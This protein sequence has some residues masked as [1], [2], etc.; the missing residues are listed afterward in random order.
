MSACVCHQSGK[1]GLQFI[2]KTYTYHSNGAYFKIQWM[3]NSWL[4]FKGINSIVNEPTN[5]TNTQHA[6][7]TKQHRIF[8]YIF[9]RSSGRLVSASEL[10]INQLFQLSLML[11]YCMDK[12]FTFWGYFGCIS[13]RSDFICVLPTNRNS[14]ESRILWTLVEVKQKNGKRTRAISGN[15]FCIAVLLVSPLC[16]PHF[17]VLY[18]HV[19][20]CGCWKQWNRI[21]HREKKNFIVLC[22]L[23]VWAMLQNGKCNPSVLFVGN[24]NIT[25]Y[26]TLLTFEVFL[27]VFGQFSEIKP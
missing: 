26:T 24:M 1:A 19:C 27:C 14:F 20:G 4:E 7:K 13:W 8:R 21:A 18:I 22:E 5:T 25:V 23:E 10:Q 17:D 16:K 9:F 15:W 6:P 3:W 2:C 11:I 12:I